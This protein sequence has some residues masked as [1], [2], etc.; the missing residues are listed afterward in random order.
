M[1]LNIDKKLIW[2]RYSQYLYSAG[3]LKMFSSR[4]RLLLDI[5]D[6]GCSTP[7]KKKRGQS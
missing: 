7:Q 1:K 5:L 6:G 3:V 2:E 4:S